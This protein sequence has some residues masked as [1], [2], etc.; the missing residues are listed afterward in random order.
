MK[1]HVKRYIIIAVLS[2]LAAQAVFGV[3]TFTLQESGMNLCSNFDWT[4]IKI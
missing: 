1:R 3:A 4:S 2:L